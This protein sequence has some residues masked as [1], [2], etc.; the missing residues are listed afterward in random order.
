MRKW[1]YYKYKNPR[2]RG[3]FSEYAKYFEKSNAHYK[4]VG[5]FCNNEGN[6]DLSVTDTKCVYADKK[7][8]STKCKSQL[9][10]IPLFD[11]VIDEKKNENY[12]KTEDCNVNITL[13]TKKQI[14]AAMLKEKKIPLE[15]N[16]KY[17][18]I[19]SNSRSSVEKWNKLADE[20]LKMYD[21][22]IQTANK[23]IYSKEKIISAGNIENIKKKN[24]ILSIKSA[25]MTKTNIN[26]PI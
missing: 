26:K 22:V 19:I 12:D 16:P 18:V 15:M 21:M 3:D 20:I 4:P 23:P 8:N 1:N 24:D 14:I 9:D 10:D 5:R 2:N 7:T 6:V 25:V 17:K 11:A 13:D